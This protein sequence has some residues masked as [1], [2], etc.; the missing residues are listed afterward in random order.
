[1]AIITKG[2]IGC[3]DSL[4]PFYTFNFPIFRAEGWIEKGGYTLSLYFQP[5]SL[6]DTYFLMNILRVNVVS[7]AVSV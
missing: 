6:P 5:S 3:G 4:L 7:A 2:K 1:M